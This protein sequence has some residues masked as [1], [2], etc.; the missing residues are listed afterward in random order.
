MPVSF[1]TRAQV[2]RLQGERD[3]VS[4]AVGTAAEAVNR[5]ASS[6]TPE[7]A[8][9]LQ[10]VKR[11]IERCHPPPVTGA[12]MG[13]LTEEQWRKIMATVAQM[14]KASMHAIEDLS[15]LKQNATPEQK[16]AIDS[17]KDALDDYVPPEP[18][19]LRADLDDAV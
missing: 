3:R 7:Q 10:S 5:I 16:E 14:R 4:T 18:D 19:D 8:A 15:V 17:V 6:A 11:L 9:E 13:S 2:Q 1:C 12:R